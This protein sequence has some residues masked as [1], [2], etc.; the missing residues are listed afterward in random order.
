MLPVKL[1]FVDSLAQ[2]TSC[3]L[4]IHHASQNPHVFLS[5]AGRTHYHIVAI[6]D[7][8]RHAGAVWFV[9]C[10]GQIAAPPPHRS[11]RRAGAG[12]RKVCWAQSINY[13]RPVASP[14]VQHL[15]RFQG[16]G[17]FQ[18]SEV[19]WHW[20]ERGLLGERP[21]RRSQPVLLRRPSDVRTALEIMAADP[22]SA[23]RRCASLPVLLL[24]GAVPARLGG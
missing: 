1:I 3:V 2:S 22:D 10:E 24:R 9:D 11:G 8:D 15:A 18:R 20:A 5:R 19:P 14:Q 13:A 16:V 12:A 4:K 21:G 6:Q 17:S 7:D 23:P